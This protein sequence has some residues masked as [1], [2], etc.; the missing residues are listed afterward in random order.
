MRYNEYLIRKPSGGIRLISAPDPELKAY[1][2]SLL[3]PIIREVERLHWYEHYA[4]NVYSYRPGKSCKSLVEDILDFTNDCLLYDIYSL[5]VKDFFGSITKGAFFH[6]AD[7]L[8]SIGCLINYQHWE[9]V[10]DAICIGEGKFKSIAQ[11]NPLSPFVSN[12]VG[13][14]YLDVPFR[15]LFLKGEEKYFRYSDNIYIISKRNQEYSRQVTWDSLMHFL[16]IGPEAVLASEFTFKAK[17]TSNRQENV[18]LG[19]RLGVKP[20]LND[21]KWYRSFFYRLHTRGPAMLKDKDIL[22]YFGRLSY[23]KLQEIS[24]GLAAYAISIDPSMAGYIKQMTPMVEVRN[25]QVQ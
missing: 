10:W 5:D 22:K 2:E 24:R 9:K 3:A 23:P 8:C 12:L 25:A 6:A 19:I 7:S 11:G 13:W 17:V 1:S 21:K 15:T 16:T 4:T 20:Q 14:K 18:I